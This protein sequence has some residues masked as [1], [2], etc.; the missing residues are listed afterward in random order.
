MVV[1]AERRSQNRSDEQAL[2]NEEKRQSHVGFP[3]WS[4]PSMSAPPLRVLLTV[5]SHGARRC[6][7][8]NLDA[9]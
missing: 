7:F 1:I 6:M 5:G 8:Y 4:S 2:H 9:E 3:S